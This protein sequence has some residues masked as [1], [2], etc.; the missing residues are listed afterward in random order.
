MMFAADAML[1]F[2][3]SPADPADDTKCSSCNSL[4]WQDLYQCCNAVEASTSHVR[5]SF[6]VQGFMLPDADLL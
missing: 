2:S 4:L 3:D 6:R 1:L 5:C